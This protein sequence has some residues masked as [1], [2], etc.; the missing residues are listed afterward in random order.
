MTEHFDVVV[1]GAG[2]SGVGAGY[3]LQANSPERSYVI[4]E[5]RERLGG[6]WDLFRYPGIRSDSDM[7]TLGFSFRPWTEA[8]AIADGPSILN[9]LDETA[10]EFGID[11]HIRY[12]H[13][14]KSASWSSAD[15]LWTVTAEQDGEERVFTCGFLFMCTGYYNYA[16]GYA[17][18]F[19]GAEDFQGRIVH[20]Q[21]WTPDIDYKGKRVVVIGSGATAVT[22]VPEIAREAA[23]VTMLQRSPTYIVARPSEDG[24]ANWL[25]RRLPSKTAYAITRWKN[26]LL[27]QYFFRVARK[28]PAKA[29]EKIIEMVRDELG[30]DYDIGTH[31][32]PRYNPWDQRLCL[33]PDADLFAAIREGK[34]DVV[35]D[36]IDHFTPTG[37]RLH[38]GKEL[39]ADLV[40]TATGLE[41]QLVSDIPFSVDGKP[42]EWSR[43]VSYKGMMFSDVPNM[44]MSFGY[45]N[46]SWT[47]K[48]DLT[49]NYVTRLLNAMRKR[50]MQQVTPRLGAPIEEAPFL[51]FTSGYVQRAM[52]KF[53]RRGT[54][55]PWR[56]DQ[57]YTRDV[58]ALKYGGLDQEMEFSNP[59]RK[60]KAAA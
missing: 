7:F 9:Y 54:R 45:T 30:P 44:A 46:A 5:G 1:V 20:P 23:S 12:R 53:P 57:S 58:M 37:L 59:A 43:H 14:V 10:R 29:K 21:F 38:S 56:V 49:A 42:I 31:F 19:A 24:I 11:R 16:R 25:R 3:H 36:T 15:A 33:V 35:T 47:L 32:T 48:A 41:I 60:V 22:L 28:H 55:A 50:G 8:K 6:T 39:E 2:I 26:V 13:R 17:P 40:V 51:D 18:E 4:L 52:E 27:Q 34:A